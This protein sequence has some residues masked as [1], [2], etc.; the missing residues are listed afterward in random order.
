MI[1]QAGTCPCI[2]DYRCTAAFATGYFTDNLLFAHDRLFQHCKLNEKTR[3][4]TAHSCVVTLL[5]KP[6][7]CSPNT[8]IL[9]KNDRSEEHTSEHQS[10]MR[11]SYAGLCFKKKT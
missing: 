9:R 6:L 1:H 4:R 10:L 8:R 7:R 11:T 2:L 3:A 5:C